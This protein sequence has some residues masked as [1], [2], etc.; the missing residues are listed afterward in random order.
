MLFRSDFITKPVRLDELL[1]W[2]GR[3]LLLQWHTTPP[4]PPPAA[5][6]AGAICPPRAQ[7][8][9]LHDLVRLGYPR[10]V[11]QLLD[12]IEAE[13]PDG[14]AWLAPLRALA[15]GFQFERMTP[16]IQDA[17]ARSQTA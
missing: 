13:R 2:L 11:H 1:D 16:V 17:L 15:H 3:Q 14:S 10:G 8:Q 6:P 9:S 7:L 12:T 4:P 5:V